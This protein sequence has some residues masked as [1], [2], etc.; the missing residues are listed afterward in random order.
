VTLRAQASTAFRRARGRR[1]GTGCARRTRDPQAA[2]LT[3]TR[4]RRTFFLSCT[5]SRSF[6]Q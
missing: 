4:A 6:I 2:A 1:G 5:P 3:V